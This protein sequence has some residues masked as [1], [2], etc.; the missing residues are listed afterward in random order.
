MVSYA[1]VCYGFMQ[2]LNE[3]K[4]A[5]ACTFVKLFVLTLGTLFVCAS[6]EF[7]SGCRFDAFVVH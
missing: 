6:S 5:R 4:L 1:P 3:A 7:V 2:I